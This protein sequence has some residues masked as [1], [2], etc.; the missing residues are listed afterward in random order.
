MGRAVEAA[1]IVA[2][3]QH[4][5]RIRLAPAGG[6]KSTKRS[7]AVLWMGVRHDPDLKELAQS[8]EAA[9]PHPHWEVQFGEANGRSEKP[10]K[11]HITVGRGN[12]TPE[13]FGMRLDYEQPFPFW[14]A[15]QF[16]LMQTVPQQQRVNGAKSRYNIVHTFPFGNTHS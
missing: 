1:Q 13:Y 16:V 4:T 5:F 15:S 9:V 3:A 2:K 12:F 14:E 8:L 6:F 10:Y 7:N 11:P